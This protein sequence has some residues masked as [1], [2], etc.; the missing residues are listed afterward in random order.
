MKVIRYSEY[1][2]QVH[3]QTHHMEQVNYLLNEFDINGIPE[4]L[5]YEIQKINE[6]KK[7]LYVE[8]YEDFKKGIWVFIDGHKSNMSLN[9]LKKL[10][11]CWEADFPDDI[12]VYDVN[13]DH[14]L[15]L[16]DVEC[17]YFGCYVPARS[18]E[19]ISN[20]RRRKKEKA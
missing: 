4:F 12:D 2:F 7:K 17:T 10:V 1:G 11:P 9:H 6:K 20:I 8:N 3:E 16:S 19:K 18:L 15:K 14:K 13:W 5:R